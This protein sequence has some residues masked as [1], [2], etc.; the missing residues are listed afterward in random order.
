[1]ITIN[2]NELFIP[3]LLTIISSYATFKIGIKPEKQKTSRLLY[4]KSFLPIFNYVENDL[5]SKSITVKEAH[6]IANQIII[7]LSNSDGYYHPS[8][9]DY[10]LK[11]KRSNDKDYMKHWTYFSERFSYR[12]DRLC[13][14]IGI[15]LRNSSYR[16][17]HKHYKNKFELIKLFIKLSWPVLFLLVLY[18]LMIY[19]WITL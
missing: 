2:L 5:Y 7:L 3:V 18:L 16:I 12:Y 13:K 14:D 11:L 9:K 6:E 8:V 15:P 19:S 10:A 17:N 4:E 1:M